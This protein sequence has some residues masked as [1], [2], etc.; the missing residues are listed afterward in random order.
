M[1]PHKFDK[2]AFKDAVRQCYSIA[3]VL[4]RLGIKS[5]GT[6]Y[7]F[8]NRQVRILSLDTTHW[9]G[10]AHLKGKSHSWTKAQPLSEILVANSSYTAIDSLKKRLLK[11]G[12]LEY[13]CAICHLVQWL[14]RP[15][16]LNL[17]HIN[18]ISNDHRLENLR[19]LCPNC[20]AQTETF[21]SKNAKRRER[22][23]TLCFDCQKPI[24]R[25]SIRC[26]SCASQVPR[27][28]KIDWP[29]INQLLQE[30]SSTSYRAV[31]R[32]LGVSD[33][34]IRKHIE[35]HTINGGHASH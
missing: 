11:A 10:Q 28:T 30:V 27:Q 5:S 25:S 20:H 21:G 3:E 12:L 22:K 9:L 34:A 19:L 29:P 33:N 7:R 31:A 4:R 8:V 2:L 14:G 17:D 24:N 16:S 18:G 32:G 15:L 6:T 13:E 1:R 35:R 23:Q 26:K